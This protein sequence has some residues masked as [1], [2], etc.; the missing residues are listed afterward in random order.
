MFNCYSGSTG[1]MDLHFSKVSFIWLISQSLL[2]EGESLTAISV[3]HDPDQI[4]FQGN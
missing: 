2:N 4:I 1:W 3:L